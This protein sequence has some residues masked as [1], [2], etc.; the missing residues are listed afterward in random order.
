MSRTLLLF[1]PVSGLTEG[2]NARTFLHFAVA[3]LIMTTF[4]VTHRKV[5]DGIRS[6]TNITYYCR[7]LFLLFQYLQEGGFFDDVIP[8]TRKI[9]IL[10]HIRYKESV[11]RTAEKCNDTENHVEDVLC[12][13][14]LTAWTPVRWKAMIMNGAMLP[15]CTRCGVYLNVEYFRIQS[16][17]QP[18]NN[19]PKYLCSTPRVQHWNTVEHS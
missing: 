1:L 5:T 19:L 8:F 15:L 12:F 9:M 4:S 18:E 13:E 14:E 2:P 16:N 11:K 3:L 10:H 17:N 7:G 6:T